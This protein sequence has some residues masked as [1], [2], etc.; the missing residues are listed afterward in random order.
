[1]VL[2]I[3]SFQLAGLALLQ[4]LATCVGLL[5]CSSSKVHKAAQNLI[6]SVDRN[7][8]KLLSMKELQKFMEKLEWLQ[9]EP[10]VD[11]FWKLYARSEGASHLSWMKYRNRAHDIL[12]Q[13]DHFF[14]FSILPQFYHPQERLRREL[15]RWRAADCDEDGRLSREEFSAF[16]QPDG[17]VHMQELVSM[18]LMEQ[19]DYNNDGVLVYEEFARQ[20]PVVVR[21]A[22]E[23][24]FQDSHRQQQIHDEFQEKHRKRGMNIK[25]LYLWLKQHHFD[26]YAHA[27]QQL[28]D[29]FD[30]NA[31]QKLSE[32]EMVSNCGRFHQSM[33]QKLGEDMLQLAL[34]YLDH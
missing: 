24:P 19:L 34:E 1:M 7:T 15:R 13:G 4:A 29:T 6:D 33:R 12:L 18:E 16:I 3:I 23:L 20:R 30:H 22:D 28:I 5:D 21:N 11:H 2:A 10:Q 8:D 17:Y 31:D 25:E 14:S 27:A 32:Q 9:L 26:N